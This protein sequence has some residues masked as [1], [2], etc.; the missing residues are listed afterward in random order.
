MP[1]T[2]SDL[3]VYR[4]AE[5]SDLSTNGGR[6]S[7]TQTVSGV[8]GNIFPNVT[9]AQRVAG[10]TQHRKVFFKN[11]HVDDLILYN[12]FFYQETNTPGDDK[13]LWWPASQTSLQS[14]ITGSER[15]YGCGKLNSL[16]NSGAT[17]LTV[18][19]EDGAQ[20]IF[21]TGDTIRVSDKATPSSGTGNE[22]FAV[23]LSRSILGNVVT[24]NLVTGLTYGYAANAKV[25]TIYTVGDVKPT[26][27]LDSSSSVGGTVDLTGV[28]MTLYNLSTDSRT[29]TLTFSSPTAF[30]L[31]G[32]LGAGTIAGGCA[33]INPATGTPYFTIS[34]SAFTGAFLLSDVFS[35]TTTPAAFPVWVR[36]IVPG[37]SAVIGDNSNVFVLDGETA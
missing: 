25:S 8:A 4:S 37:G 19:V 28:N 18:G 30:T 21:Q 15:K 32:G 35:F 36:R 13:V 14:A 31:S 17:V 27:T 10:L 34:P 26:V 12:G 11:T 29:V 16:V 23:V 9:Q 22:D 2:S 5:V 20:D 7:I 3:K 6:I 24:I 1:I 33:P